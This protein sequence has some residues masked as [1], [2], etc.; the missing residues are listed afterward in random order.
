MNNLV[1]ND[2]PVIDDLQ[3]TK[4]L[5]QMLVNTPYYARLGSD[6]IFAIIETAKSL[7]IDPK[8]ALGG[9]LYYVKGK[10]EMSSRLMNSMIRAQ[11]HSITMDLKSND[12]IC[13]LHGK[14]ADNGDTWTE[15]FSMEEANKAGLINTTVW[16]NFAR[17][18]LFARALSR[19][20]RRL[21]PDI[22]G[23]VYVEG[24]I[25]F[26]PNIMDRTDT[27]R[28]SSLCS[29]DKANIYNQGYKSFEVS[30]NDVPKKKIFKEKIF[31]DP[32]FQETEEDFLQGDLNTHPSKEEIDALESLIGDDN[33]YRQKVMR[34]LQNNCEIFSLYDMPKE[35]YDKVY[36]RALKNKQERE[37]EKI[38]PPKAPEEPKGDV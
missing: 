36:V 24:E 38:E 28:K 23:N 18:M 22:I 33:E 29:V 12:T 4:N 9:S 1:K 20:A 19:L 8:L 3:N 10:V 34:F 21:F 11:K 32:N 6:G 7:N 15:S 35:I 13:I 2:I 25:S 27:H 17:D 14:R 31:F 30:I 16:K 37:E 26:D 5:C